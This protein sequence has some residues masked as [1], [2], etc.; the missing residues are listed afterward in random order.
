MSPALGTPGSTRLETSNAARPPATT[1]AQRH[2]GPL[3]NRRGHEHEATGPAQA[4]AQARHPVRANGPPGW[5]KRGGRHPR[6]PVPQQGPGAPAPMRLSGSR[7]LRARRCSTDSSASAP[8]APSA[9]RAA[10][11]ASA[12]TAW[13]HTAPHVCPCLACLRAAARHEAGR[14]ND[15]AQHCLNKRLCIPGAQSRRLEHAWDKHTVRAFC[16]TWGAAAGGKGSLQTQHGR[17]CAAWPA[18]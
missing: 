8:S 4:S 12:P 16:T 2:C 1:G 9:S 17:E 10:A 5:E 15:A 7:L 18:P 14:C 13:A 3:E 11:T 6:P